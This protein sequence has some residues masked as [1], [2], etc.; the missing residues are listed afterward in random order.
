VQA[1]AAAPWLVVLFALGGAAIWLG[2]RLWQATALPLEL[3][4]AGLRVA[5]G[6]V[7]ARMAEIGRVG[8]GVFAFKPS[9]GFVLTLDR[10]AAAAWAPGLW[11]RLG[12]RV[13]VGGVTSR[14]EGRAMAEII[15]IEL[16]RRREVPAPPAPPPAPPG[17]PPP[18]GPPPNGPPPNGPAAG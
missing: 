3:T 7:V 9:N 5:D 16:R 1:T 17:A 14:H 4:P 18:D 12:K 15:E 6:R 11:W 2:V 8:H 13:G 10:P